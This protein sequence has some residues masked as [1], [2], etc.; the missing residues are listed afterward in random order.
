MYTV[1]LA[2]GILACIVCAHRKYAI[3]KSNFFFPFYNLQKK[4]ER[5]AKEYASV[6]FSDKYEISGAPKNS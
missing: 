1:H 3:L 5:K 6:I 4:L 2:V